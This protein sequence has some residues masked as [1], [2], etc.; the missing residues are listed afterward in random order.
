[1]KFYAKENIVE[2]DPVFTEDSRTI[3]HVKYVLHE[4]PV[5]EILHFREFFVD[6]GRELQRADGADR[7]LACFRHNYLSGESV[8]G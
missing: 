5:L 6:H 4:L 8:S 2:L 7:A 1:M 3:R